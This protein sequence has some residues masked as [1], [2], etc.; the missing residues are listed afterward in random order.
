M[1]KIIDQVIDHASMVARRFGILEE[2]NNPECGTRPWNIPDVSMLPDAPADELSKETNYIAPVDP[3]KIEGVLLRYG[4]KATFLDYRIGSAVTTYEIKV[5]MGTKISS[6]IRSRDDI[7]RDIGAPSLRIIQSINNS[8]TIGFEV[9]NIDR[10]MVH[11][12]NMFLDIPGNLKLPVILGEDTYGEKT[13]V[14]LTLLP[15]LLVAGRTGS[16]KS[17]FINTLI[18]TLIC[19]FT[20]EQLQLILVDPK[21]VE[22][23]AYENLPHL[24]ENDGEPLKIA[25]N[26]EEARIVLEVAVAE[27]ERRFD[28]LKQHRAKK[29]DDY[30]AVATEKLP[31]IVFIVDEFADLMLMGSSADRKEVENQ[32]IRIAQKARAVGIHMILSTQKPLAQI[33]TTLIK[34]NMPAR[35]S[36]SVT[37]AGDSRVILDEGGA[38]A[39]AG[40]GDM[41]YQDPLARNEYTRIKR[42]Q[43]PW[44][45]D[46]IIEQLIKQGE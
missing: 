7:A 15:H 16:G 5:P 9:E 39:L 35:I 2:L 31:Y 13:Y 19:K 25:S 26:A 21:Q 11:F 30:N 6:L 22:F 23:A 17:V 14:D 42:I 36:F 18:T 40:N 10:Y 37:S 34:A 8:S 3:K 44:I 32:I 20:P 24:F 41:L 12:K 4:I 28:L 46:S 1:Y 38:E 45:S 29:I 33:M 43:A 27:M